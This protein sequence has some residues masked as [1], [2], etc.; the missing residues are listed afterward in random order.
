LQKDALMLNRCRT[1]LESVRMLCEL[2]HK[3]EK[4]KR[5]Y[6]RIHCARA[7]ARMQVQVCE[8]MFASA[9]RQPLPVVL[10]D[11]IARLR[12]KDR[13]HKIFHYPVTEQVRHH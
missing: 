2:V 5:D 13:H 6:V 12:N 3:R 7:R 4:R 10:A 9:V 8:D 1:Q 11:C